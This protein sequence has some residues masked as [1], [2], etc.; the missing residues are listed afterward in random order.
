M[1][2]NELLHITKNLQRQALDA[3]AYREIIRQYH[4]NLKE[5]SVEMKYSSAF[6][7]IVYQSLH[8]SLLMCFHIFISSCL[9]CFANH[10]L[11]ILFPAWLMNCFFIPDLLY[12]TLPTIS[13]REKRT[14]HIFI[15]LQMIESQKDK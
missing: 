13:H 8:E 14:I 2:T 11:K 4:A 5:Y 1:N 15:Y 12:Y 7:S 9:L 10:A 3:Y 6:Y